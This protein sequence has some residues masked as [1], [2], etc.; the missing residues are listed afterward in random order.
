MISVLK[1]FGREYHEQSKKDRPQYIDA[2]IELLG[3][4]PPV[5]AKIK[6]LQQA[7]KTLDYNQRTAEEM[8]WKFSLDN[9]N[10]QSVASYISGATNIPLDRLMRKADNVSQVLNDDWENWQK[11]MM[12]LGWNKWELETADQKEKMEEEKAKTT[13]RRRKETYEKNKAEKKREK[14]KANA[15][16]G[17]ITN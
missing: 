10:Y 1:N 16:M 7:G 12:V 11:V 5:Q 8:G 13:K 4:A 14:S 9:P 2:W 6:R 15:A 17:L 3:I